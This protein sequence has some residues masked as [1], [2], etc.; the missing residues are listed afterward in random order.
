MLQIASVFKLF[1][2]IVVLICFASTGCSGVSD[3][4]STTDLDNMV[5][6]SSSVSPAQDDELKL[7]E[8]NNDTLEFE[9]FARLV[10]AVDSLDNDRVCPDPEL[11]SSLDD[12]VEVGRIVDGCVKLEYVALNGDSVGAVRER[13]AN[14]STVFAVGIPPF[15]LVPAQTIAF[16]DP[17]LP[18]WHLERIFADQLWSPDGWTYV[19]APGETRSIAGWP[20]EREVVVA[21][22]DDGVDGQ[23]RDLAGN[24]LDP[25]RLP[26]GAQDAGHQCHREPLGDHGTHVS[27]IIAAV[28]GNGQDV[29][30]VAPQAT[31]LPIKVHFSA[32]LVNVNGILNPT[33]PDCFEIVPTLT[34]AINLARLGGADVVNMSLRWNVLER[35]FAL[36]ERE[37]RFSDGGIRSNTV[38]FAIDLIREQNDAV[39][40][41]AAGN[42]GRVAISCSAVN[43]ENMPASNRNVISVAATDINNTRAGFSSANKTVDMAAPG[44]DILSTVRFNG[45]GVSSGT[46]MAAPV[47]AAAVA[48]IRARYPALSPREIELA[49]KVTASNSGSPND[50]LGFGVVNPVAAIERLDSRLQEL[51]FIADTVYGSIPLITSKGLKEPTVW[52]SLS[53]VASVEWSPQGTLALVEYRQLN[54][55]YGDGY[56][57]PE[58]RWSLIS[59]NGSLVKELDSTVANPNWSPDGQRIAY[60]ANEGEWEGDWGGYS[61]FVA[62]VYDESDRQDIGYG[63]RPVWSPNNRQIMFTE[64]SGPYTTRFA[65][66][67]SDG[68]N[69]WYVNETPNP[70]VCFE[71]DEEGQ[72]LGILLDE[73]FIR[74]EA[75]W[76]PDGRQIAYTFGP[77]LRLVD[78][79]GGGDRNLFVGT[80]AKVWNPRWSPDGQY[81]AFVSSNAT[82]YAAS[83]DRHELWIVASDGGH[84]EFI[85]EVVPHSEFT[86]SPDSTNIAYVKQSPD[87]D[88]VIHTIAIDDTSNPVAVSPPNSSNPVWSRDSSVIAFSSRGD[89][90]GGSPNDSEIYFVQADGSGLVQVTDNEHDDHSPTWINSVP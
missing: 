43:Q 1:S 73:C 20:E 71:V 28:Q 77:E 25:S 12:V 87:Q 48:H 41:A 29:A 66:A 16:D 10:T 22:I 85:S 53:E 59:S 11:P 4:G 89:G 51:S 13:L 84:N 6:G 78:S 56:L 18:Q 47:V 70:D 24:L 81:I 83:E 8:T 39:L 15:D 58:P 82:D 2:S 23:H 37:P 5:D 63:F 68:R 38:D 80:Y 3:S 26:N 30:G 44:E 61:V 62:D 88:G 9:Y 50:E 27:G 54:D 19:N 60:S 49:L 55:I 65:V 76:T 34:H 52:G 46:S 67:D 32:D 17:S 86:W 7:E 64:P 69:I 79:G 35:E 72:P 57:V 21:V 40:V 33:D 74:Q 90:D 14:D 75:A 36:F 42:C 31:I 45:T